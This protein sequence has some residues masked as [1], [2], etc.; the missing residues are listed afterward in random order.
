M[1]LCAINI[2]YSNTFSVLQHVF[3]VKTK[4]SSCSCT[5]VIKNTA[6]QK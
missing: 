5:K 3:K 6:V 2:H 4:W 1:A